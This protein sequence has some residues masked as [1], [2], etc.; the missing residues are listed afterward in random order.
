MLAARHGD[1][2]VCRNN[3][4]TSEQKNELT[5]EL[6]TNYSLTHHVCISFVCKVITDVKLLL[7]YSNTL[8]HLTVLKQMINSK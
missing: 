6:P 5:I 7:L 3:S 4:K 8:K 1:G 2:E